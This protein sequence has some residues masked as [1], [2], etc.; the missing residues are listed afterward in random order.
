MP[1]NLALALEPSD[2]FVGLLRLKAVI[3]A[4]R[5][6][7]EIT[8]AF[9]TSI[10]R[11]FARLEDTVRTV[12]LCFADLEEAGVAEVNRTPQ[13]RFDDIDGA[14]HLCA[15]TATV[16]LDLDH[17]RVALEH[18][19]RPARENIAR[20][21]LTLRSL[22]WYLVRTDL[23]VC[24]HMALS[25]RDVPPE[26][27]LT[28]LDTYLAPAWTVIAR[29]DPPLP[30]TTVPSD[31]GNSTHEIPAQDRVRASDVP[32]TESTAVFGPPITP[33]PG[34]AASTAP[35]LSP[36]AALSDDARFFLFQ[37][38]VHEA[39]WPVARAVLQSARNNVL[40][41]L[42]PSASDQ[43]AAI[44][45]SLLDSA[46]RGADEVLRALDDLETAALLGIDVSTTMQIDAT[47]ALSD[48]ARFFLLQCGA[49]WPCDPQLLHTFRDGL[50]ARSAT[51]EGVALG[52]QWFARVERGF[53]ELS[54]ISR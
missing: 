22:V 34:D 33:N 46:E 49:A 18:G 26:R 36:F 47:A 35:T 53:R 45:A 50:L 20:L 51:P 8:M 48:D 24:T 15:C 54:R 2:A 6:P 7:A 14:L 19:D 16:S 1:R 32:L 5:W 13:S 30:N 41:R 23:F 28:F 29:A 17:L 12:G 11:E 10:D 40:R 37:A 44:T 52:P 21:A 27:A 43:S 3:E 4:G 25:E 38:D 9:R 39:D 42:Q 31:P